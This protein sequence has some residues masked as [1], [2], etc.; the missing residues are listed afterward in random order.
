VGDE[1]A[2]L[3]DEVV[4][5]GDIDRAVEALTTSGL[6]NATADRCTLRAG[7]EPLDLFGQYM[8]AFAVEQARCHLSAAL[9]RNLKVNW[10]AHERSA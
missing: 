2:M 3:C 4:E 6:M 7:Q 5:P 1:V 9:I 8:S 10:H